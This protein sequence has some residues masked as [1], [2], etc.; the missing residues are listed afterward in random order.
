[1]SVNSRSGNAVPW[2]ASALAST[3]FRARYERVLC[4]C[5]IRSEGLLVK[6]VESDESGRRQ[7]DLYT[8][9]WTIWPQPQALTWQSDK[10][11]FTTSYTALAHTPGSK[12][13]GKA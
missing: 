6:V 3:D 12:F 4:D 10:N 7:L 9:G 13:S 1:V 11:I 8:S 2:W 5:T